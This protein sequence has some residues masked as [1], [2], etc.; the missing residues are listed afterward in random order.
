VIRQDLA[1]INSRIVLE[2]GRAR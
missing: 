2:E 1:T